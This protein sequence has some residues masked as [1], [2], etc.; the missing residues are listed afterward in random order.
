MGQYYK[1]SKIGTCESMYYM[2]LSEAQELA[3]HGA[4]DD[5][6]IKFS[7]YLT[8]GRTKWRF[9]F[10]DEDAGIPDDCKYNKSFMIPSGDIE[11]G[12]GE[13]C[14]SNNIDGGNNVNIFLPC[15]YSKEFK[16]AG[17]RTSTGG[18]GQQMLKVVMEGMRDGKVKTI[19]ECARCGEMQ[20][21]SDDDVEKIKKAAIEYFEPYDTTGKNPQYD[22]NQGLFDYAM[23]IIKRIH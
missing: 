3:K 13:I 5:D 15:P 16:E 4:A 2:R 11:V 12:H 6:G 18:P 20:R 23:E 17:I 19:F 7:D 14:I 1:K 10:P 21:F 8:D 22:G 9:P